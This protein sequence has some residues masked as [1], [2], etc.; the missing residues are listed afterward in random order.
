MKP[1]IYGAPLS[2]Y[3]R[4]VRLFLETKGVEYD[5]KMIVPYATPDDYSALNPLRRVP[6]LEFDG[7]TLA[8]SA[9]ICHFLEDKFPETTLIPKDAYLRARCAWF[10]KYADYELAPLTTFTAFKERVLTRL[11]GGEPDETRI[12]KAVDLKLPPLLDYLEEEL[13]GD[14]F[15]GNSLSLADIAIASQLISFEHSGEQLDGTRW[16]KLSQFLATFCGRTYVQQMIESEQ[17]A[18]K[19]LL[20]H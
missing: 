15:V 11:S 16:P 18:L 2:P 5:S 8:D 3:V 20:G 6:A 14:H 7:Q 9:V 1:K 12:R 13:S 10:E 17:E 19:K 4:K